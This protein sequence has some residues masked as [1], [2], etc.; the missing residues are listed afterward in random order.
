V[1]QFEPAPA[2]AAGNK[3]KIIIINSFCM[4]INKR[5]IGIFGKCWKE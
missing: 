1:F 5:I 4:G 3:E 2:L